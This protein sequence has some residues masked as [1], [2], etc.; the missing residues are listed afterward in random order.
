VS[1]STPAD[2]Q[3]HT[4]HDTSSQRPDQRLGQK[5]RFEDPN[6]DL[7]FVAA[8]GWGPAGGLDIG[9]AFHVASTIKDGDADSWVA[10]FSR[11]GEIQNAQADAWKVR[12][13]RR[14]AGEARLKAFASFRSAWQFAPPG[15][16][17]VSLVAKQRVAFAAALQE[18][19]FPAT[20]FEVPFK[21]KQLPGVFL[22]HPM[23]NAPVVLVIGGADTSF[24]DLFFTIGRGL[25]DRGYSVALVD[26]PGQGV[27]QAEGLHWEV[28]AEKPIG[29]VTDLLV[30]RFDAQP[31]RIALVGLSLGGYFV[32]RAAGYE[33][34]LAAVIAS[35]P[36]PNPA[37]LFSLSVQAVVASAAEAASTAA[38]RSRQ[39]TFWKTGASNAQEFLAR[40]AGMV[41]DPSRV[42]VPFLSIVGAAD[43]KVFLEQAQ[44]WH[45]DIRSTRK[46]FVLLN[47]ETGA[48]GHV[49]A[50]NRL[51]LVQESS[52]WLN[53]I[54]RL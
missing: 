43:S 18:L 24:D 38:L 22:K 4:S 54:F 6:M 7:F 52:G 30:E 28:E 51:R 36:F 12:G 5:Y 17:F 33:T 49:Q 9:Q 40:T 21:G 32:T 8:L 35:T 27:T 10:S 37:Q 31:G 23:A 29:A 25:F 47:R 39:I 41:A 20:H 53:E 1:A 3:S 15:P 11:Y 2:P 46:D 50:N 44:G 42:T 16:V 48:D 14:A 19:S 34:R 45:R 13:W 26:L